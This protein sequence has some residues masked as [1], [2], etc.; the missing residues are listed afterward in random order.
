MTVKSVIAAGLGLLLAG[1]AT[2]LADVNRQPNLTAVGSG[3]AAGAS[4]PVNVAAYPVADLKDDPGWEGSSADLFRDR[5]AAQIGDTVRVKIAIDDR[6]SLDSTSDRSRR[7]RVEGSLDFTGLFNAV[8]TIGNGKATLDSRSNYTG[9]GATERAETVELLVAAVVTD[10]L[11]NGN[12]VVRGT[13]EVRVNYEVRELEVGGIVD[14]L[15]ITGNNTV[16]YDRL[17]EARISYGGRGRIDEVQQPR[18]GQQ[19]YDLIAP[20]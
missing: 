13:Q 19:V 2:D 10:V 4:P 7:A 12:L 17:A 1:C 5:R 8:P 14:P 6:A 11:A 16:D 15:D 18:W 9:E 3:L 20:F